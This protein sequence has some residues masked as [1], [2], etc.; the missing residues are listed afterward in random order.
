MADTPSTPN[1]T[2]PA[3]KPQQYEPPAKP[4]Q[5]EGAKAEQ[6]AAPKGGKAATPVKADQQLPKITALTITVDPE[7][8]SVV[9]IE[10]LDTSGARH[11]LSNE[12]KAS[13]VGEGR[14]A[15]R[16]GTVVEEAFEAGIASVLGESDEDE[17]DV[18]PETPEDAELRRMLLAPL[19]ARGAVKR[20]TERAA[21]NRAILGTLIEHSM[22]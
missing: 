2:K 13:L 8:A 9:R 17:Q 19:L 22:K 4:G 5:P 3:V 18:T 6:Q 12:E 7:S 20:L 15:E 16:L 10:G 1:T 11:E 14:L 21:L